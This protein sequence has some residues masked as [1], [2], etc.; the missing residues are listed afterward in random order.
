MSYSSFGFKGSGSEEKISNCLTGWLPF[1]SVPSPLF[2]MDCLVSDKKRSHFPL[3][4][5]LLLAEAI[6][7]LV[8]GSSG[9]LSRM[10][11]KASDIKT[12][13]RLNISD[14]M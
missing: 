13:S 14:Y 7:F 12:V 11:A 1:T 6:Q 4:H 3:F 5:S 10:E 9:C 2:G 8:L